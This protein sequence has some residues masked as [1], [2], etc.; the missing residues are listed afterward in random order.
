[1]A[2]RVMRGAGFVIALAA[3]LAVSACSSSP[4][5]SKTAAQLIPEVQAASEQATSVHIAGSV[6]QRSQTTTIDVRID[7]DSVAGTLGAYGTSYYVLSLNGTSFV[8]LNAAFLKVKNAPASLCVKICGKYVE[9]TA[10]SASKIT[11]VL[12]MQQLIT[13]VFNNQTMTE[14]A[15]STCVFSPATR[16][17]QS[18]LQCRQG[19][20]TLDVAAHGQPYLVYWG[21]P[22]GQHLSFSDWNSVTLPPAPPASQVVSISDLG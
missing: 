11:S 3:G 7:G 13:D 19:S 2:V 14:A 17:D 21:G 22:N 5:G 9:L 18:V 1:M 4:A 6:T 8:K 20:Y 16:G 10:A 12:S 15:A